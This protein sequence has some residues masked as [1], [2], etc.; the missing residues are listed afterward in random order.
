MNFIF[1]LSALLVI[2]LWRRVDIGLHC[3]LRWLLIAYAHFAVSERVP[4]HLISV[5]N[6]HTSCYGVA[7]HVSLF[8]PASTRNDD[9]IDQLRAR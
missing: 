1:R 8:S 3:M 2:Y 9:V 6:L 7:V 4:Y 5:F